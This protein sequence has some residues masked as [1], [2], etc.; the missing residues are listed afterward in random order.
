M[1]AQEGQR[2]H[3]IRR[4]SR[5]SPGE[6]RSKLNFERWTGAHQR[7]EEQALQERPH[8]H[9]GWGIVVPNAS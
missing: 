6:M 3:N 7:L 1:Q 9:G 8:T 4:G 2:M 5:H